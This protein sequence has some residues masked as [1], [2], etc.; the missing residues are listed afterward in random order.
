MLYIT[1]DIHGDQTI[2]NTHLLPF[3]KPGD[4]ILVA[5]DFGIGFYGGRYLTEDQFFDEL[6]KEDITIYFID[7][8]HE[9][10]TKLYSYPVIIKNYGKVHQ[11]RKNIF[12]LM[13]G[14]IYEINRKKILCFGGGF[15]LDRD[16][17]ALSGP[18]QNWWK[19]EMPTEEEYQ[20]LIVNLKKYENKVDYVITHTAPGETVSYIAKLGLGIKDHVAEEQPLTNFLEYVRSVIDYKIWYFGHFHADI[21]TE[22]QYSLWRNQIGLYDAVRELET[23]KVVWYRGSYENGWEEKNK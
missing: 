8:N 16:W 18:N 2:W 7:G 22:S 5:G 13:R 14:E 21:G 6:E 20:N 9:A 3:L 12:H 11:I 15:S 4:E 10:F 23:G 17:R 19:E 1:G